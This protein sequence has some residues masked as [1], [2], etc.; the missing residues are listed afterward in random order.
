M[1]AAASAVVMR[2]RARRATEGV[3]RALDVRCRAV[4]SSGAGG[5]ESAVDGERIVVR[6]K[7]RWGETRAIAREGEGRRV[8]FVDGWWTEES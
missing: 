1:R 4:S 6:A 8:G 3:C 2:A 7:R 5:R